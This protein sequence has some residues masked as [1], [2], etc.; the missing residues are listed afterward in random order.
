MLDRRGVLATGATLLLAACPPATTRPAADPRPQPPTT[1][2]GRDPDA[3]RGR[4]DGFAG[5]PGFRLPDDLAGRPLVVIDRGHGGRPTG[6][7]GLR[8]IAKFTTASPAHPP[9]AALARSA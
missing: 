6:R 9:V 4:F 7:L 1:G 8:W 5:K 2:P 3:V